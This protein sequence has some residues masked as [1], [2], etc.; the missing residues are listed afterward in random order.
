MPNE[1][2]RVSPEQGPGVSEAAESWQPRGDDAVSQ[3]LHMSW[4]RGIA[5]PGQV[6]PGVLQLPAGVEGAARSPP[7]PKPPWFR[8]GSSS[9]SVTLRLTFRTS[10]PAGGTGWPSALSSTGTGEEALR[11]LWRKH[12]WRAAVRELL[13]PARAWG[14]QAAS[15]RSWQL[16]SCKMKG[17]SR[18]LWPKLRV[19]PVP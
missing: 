3:C 8:R 11:G 1:D 15:C 12:G 13:S 18:G 2:G 17:A 7:H 9:F 19:G 4:N 5:C 14:G 16:A 6:I 10:P